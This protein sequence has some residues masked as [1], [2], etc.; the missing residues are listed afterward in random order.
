MTQQVITLLQQALV[1]D[2]Q[3]FLPELILCGTIVLLLLVRLFSTFDRNHLG[4]LALVF[5]CY[6]LVVSW[7]QWQGQ[8]HDP[9]AFPGEGSLELFSGMLKFDNF[10]I[11]LRL[12]LLG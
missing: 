1:R 5:T 9:R 8:A 2:A 10:T 6:A 3:A 12:F 4:W 11:F 7:L